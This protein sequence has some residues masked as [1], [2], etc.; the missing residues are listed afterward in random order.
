MQE[1]VC[2]TWYVHVLAASP[3]TTMFRP[4]DEPGEASLGKS[5]TLP[6]NFLAEVIQCEKAEP[7]FQ[8]QHSP[9]GAL[10]ST[11]SGSFKISV[12]QVLVD[13]EPRGK[14]TIV[15]DRDGDESGAC[16]REICHL[17]GANDPK[18]SRDTVKLWLAE[19]S[20]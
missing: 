11:L 19:G 9:C 16:V 15:R 6:R 14:S 12:N 8:E 3:L 5:F 4:C 2:Q 20:Y 17:S 7:I 1:Y 10:K 13:C 18:F